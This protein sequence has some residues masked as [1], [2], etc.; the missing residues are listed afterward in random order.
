VAVAV[1]LKEEAEVLVPFTEL[2]V[3]AVLAPLTL[4]AVVVV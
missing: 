3:T 2:V 4:L 1:P